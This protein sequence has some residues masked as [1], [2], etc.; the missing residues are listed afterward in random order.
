[1]SCVNSPLQRTCYHHLLDLAGPL[2]YLGD[3]GVTHHPFHGVLL[4]IAISSQQFGP[5]LS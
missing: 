2:I 5:H 1:M 4:Y 3:L